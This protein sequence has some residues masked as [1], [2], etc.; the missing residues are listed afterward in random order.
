MIGE[1]RKKDSQCDYY[2]TPF[3]S[4][5]SLCFDPQHCSESKNERSIWRVYLAF[6]NPEAY[7]GGTA[8]PGR[9]CD[10]LS[11]QSETPF[12]AA[13]RGELKK[14]ISYVTS[15]SIPFNSS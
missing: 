1:L 7:E 5:E 9:S 8:Q 2:S 15:N 10:P 12:V 3:N 14:K 11:V 13:T 6:E 4:S